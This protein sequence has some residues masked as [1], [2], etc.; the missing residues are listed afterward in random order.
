M[1]STAVGGVLMLGTPRWGGDAVLDLSNAHVGSLQDLLDATGG[2]WPQRLRLGGFTYDRLGGDA[3]SGNGHATWL[4]KDPRFTR[5]PYQ[6]LAAALRIAGEPDAANDVLYAAHERERSLAW[7]GD[8]CRSGRG[9]LRLDDDCLTAAGL[10]VLKVTIRYGLG[11][12]PFLALAWVF[13]CT[14]TGTIVL[15]FSPAA[16]AHG[17]LWSLGA[18]LD[19]L[20]PIVDLNKEF[21]AFFDDPERKRLAGWQLGYFAVQALV[22]YVLAS[23]VVA[24][25][26]GLTQAG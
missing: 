17:L 19:Q 7:R 16:R 25:L 4:A 1:S 22:G 21:D 2:S 9:L 26:A 11:S 18:S 15:W 14:V 12:G 6:Q 5:Q 10:T 3:V 20:L 23:F 13:A 24:A 8:Q